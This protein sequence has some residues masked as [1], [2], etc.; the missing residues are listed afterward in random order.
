MDREPRRRLR[1]RRRKERDLG[2]DEPSAEGDLGG[3]RDVR[4]G[5]RDAAPR[6][7]SP[8]PSVSTPGS[9]DI[10]SLKRASGETKIP[11]EEMENSDE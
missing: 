6:P 9:A 5:K 8:P 1:R 3:E 10:V 7:T 11:G 2:H 4:L